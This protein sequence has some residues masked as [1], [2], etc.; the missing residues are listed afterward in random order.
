MFYYNFS[1]QNEERIFFFINGKKK[2]ER[3]E[4]V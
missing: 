3:Q 2:Q 4:K 1:F